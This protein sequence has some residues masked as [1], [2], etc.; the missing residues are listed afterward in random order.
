[1]RD[2]L[3]EGP[4]SVAVSAGSLGFQFYFGGIVKRFCGGE[5][6]HG[7]LAVGYGTENGKDFWIVK[8]SWGSGWGEK[9]YIRLARFMDKNDGGTCGLQK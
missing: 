3:V 8:N 4:V 1:M 2:A 5:L 7:V 6:D 9:G